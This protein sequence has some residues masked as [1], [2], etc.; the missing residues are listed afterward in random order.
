MGMEACAGA[1][2]WARQLEA[3]GLRVKLMARQFVK[4]YVKSNKNDRNDAEAICE[5]MSRPSM[6]FVSVK[7]VEQQDIQAVHR[8][9]A[10][11]VMSHDHKG[12]KCLTDVGTEGQ[13][14][15]AIWYTVVPNSPRRH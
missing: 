1:H 5:A 7:S 8:V 13:T 4:P 3:V 9:R 14:I 6:R 12:R 15:E 11:L 10:E 2:D